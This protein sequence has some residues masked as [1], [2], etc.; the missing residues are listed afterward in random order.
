MSNICPLQEFQYTNPWEVHSDKNTM[1]VHDPIRSPAD[2]TI[3]IK[4]K[5]KICRLGK[6]R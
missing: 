4:G 5:P 3:Q 6:K 2:A 1:A